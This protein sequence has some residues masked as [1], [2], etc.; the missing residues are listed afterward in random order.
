MTDT[1]FCLISSAG[2]GHCQDLLS[3]HPS[4]WDK[5]KEKIKPIA[6][7]KHFHLRAIG[8][9]IP[10]SLHLYFSWFPMFI[11]T[12]REEWCKAF[13]K[14]DFSVEDI[15]SLEVDT[16]TNLPIRCSV[17]NGKIENDP[18]FSDGEVTSLVYDFRMASKNTNMIESLFNF[19]QKISNHARPSIVRSSSPWAPTEA[20]RNSI[21]FQSIVDGS[22]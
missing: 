16:S 18:F 12:T 15:T 7:V 1:V 14:V 3:G 10:K 17:F 19:V 2:C 8:Q 4:Q 6:Y 20:L 22:T 5:I 9:K 13:P 21:T 11:C